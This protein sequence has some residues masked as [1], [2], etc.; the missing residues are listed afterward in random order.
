MV[1]IWIV[2]H[3]MTGGCW[4]M[5]QKKA[6]STRQSFHANQ[7]LV[8]ASAWSRANKKAAWAVRLYTHANHFWEGERQT[9]CPCLSSSW[10][11][12]LLVFMDVAFTHRKNTSRIFLT[13]LNGVLARSA[14][15]EESS[16]FWTEIILAG[17]CGAILAVG[18][19][20]VS[21]E[22]AL[23]LADYILY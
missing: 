11:V 3:I 9:N 17:R 10:N 4:S 22:V 2:I 18:G 8:K 21:L 12:Q 13:S 15:W 7:T 14:S 1:A 23:S 6:L 5:C 20:T 16:L 19:R